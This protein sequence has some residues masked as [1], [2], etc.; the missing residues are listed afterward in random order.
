VTILISR[1]RCRAQPS[2]SSRIEV[3]FRIFARM[4]AEMLM[5]DFQTQPGSAKLAAPAVAPQHT[6]A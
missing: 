2:G 5:M 4:A 6:L 3:F 1:A